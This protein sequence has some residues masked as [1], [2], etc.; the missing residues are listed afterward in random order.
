MRRFRTVPAAIAL[1]LFLAATSGI[2]LA[3]MPEEPENTPEDDMWLVYFALK[4]GDNP[5]DG[6]DTAGLRTLL[7]ALDPEAS[8]AADRITILDYHLTEW[9]PGLEVR[10]TA[11]PRT[12]RIGH[13]GVY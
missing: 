12:F 7:A 3:I 6:L 2:L 1:I 4:R 13:D 8:G 9:G 10:H 5:P 11:S